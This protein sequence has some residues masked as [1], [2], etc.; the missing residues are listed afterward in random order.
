MRSRIRK[1]RESGRDARDPRMQTACKVLV[2]N[3]TYIR[4]QKLLL[5]FFQ[6]LIQITHHIAKRNDAGRTAGFIH[7]RQMAE[8]MG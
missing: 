7:H 2:S 8:L 3:K 5:I 6:Y 1:Y 4:N